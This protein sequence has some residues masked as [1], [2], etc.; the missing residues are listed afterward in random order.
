[1]G[2][3]GY[4]IYR[5][6]ALVGSTTQTSYADTGLS[7]AT[8][9]AYTVAAFDGA[10]NLSQPSVALNVT[11][12]AA[13]IAFVQQ[14]YATPQSPQSQVSIPYTVSQTAGNTNIL[15]IGWNDTTA[16]ITSVTDSA[17]NVYQVAV[18]TYRGNGL[19]Q[20]IYYAPNI[21]NAA[22]GSNAIN[23]MF[24]R[25]ATYVDARIAEY[26]GLQTANTFDAGTSATGVG[27]SA[28]SGSITT[29]AANELL[30]GAGMTSS[31]FAGAGANFALRVITIPDGDILEDRLANPAGTYN[32]SAPLSAG[33]WIMQIASFKGV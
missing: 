11:T 17:G 15:V 22:A 26:A 31:R 4:D 10:N 32:A 21:K 19:S 8:G 30:I 2:V 29:I 12:P 13:A 24:D 20:A 6:G 1:L 33:T 9:Y 18:P 23:V 7:P 5:N 25:P 28:N 16:S 3:A 27:T 14:N